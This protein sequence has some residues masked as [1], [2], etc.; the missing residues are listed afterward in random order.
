M[1][2][3]K[4]VSKK[5]TFSI[6]QLQQKIALKTSQCILCQGQCKSE[7]SI[8]DYC[9]ADLPLF[10]T[11]Q[12]NLLLWPNIAKSINH[13]YFEQLVCLAPYQWPFNTWLNQLKYHQHFELAPMLANLLSKQLAHLQIIKNTTSTNDDTALVAVPSHIKRWQERGYNQSHLIAK[14]LSKHLQITYFHDVVIRQKNTEKQVGKN[15]T[16]RRKNIKNAF[17]LNNKNKELPS[18]IMLF[19]DVVTTGTT[20]NEIANLLKQSGVKHITVIAIALAIKKH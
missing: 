15:G 17:Y 9:Q 13:K 4:R 8:C 2:L 3:L 18:H 12:N 1:E 19:D 5:I 6:A 16:E 14:Q 10:T 20:V 7:P 11:S